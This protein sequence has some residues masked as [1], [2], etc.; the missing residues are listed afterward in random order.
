MFCNRHAREHGQQ[1]SKR[2]DVSRHS[3]VM[4]I[5]SLRPA[6]GPCPVPS[7]LP[8]PPRRDSI[9]RL[10]PDPSPYSIFGQGG[11]SLLGRSLRH[12]ASN[13]ST[14][15]H[16]C[17]PV[18]PRWIFSSLFFSSHP[19][20]FVSVREFSFS[21]LLIL[22]TLLLILYTLIQLSLRG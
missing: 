21:N 22:Y 6:S 13:P 2:R 5:G 3:L 10:Q 4:S 14:Y 16:A 15:I 8:R 20:L 19:S 12:P 9:I 18:V 7:P 11:A 1:R 17:F